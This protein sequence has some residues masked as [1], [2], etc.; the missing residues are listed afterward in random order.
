MNFEFLIAESPLAMFFNWI[1]H[2]EKKDTKE[3][4]KGVKFRHP[5]KSGS[6][7]IF[8]TRRTEMGFEH[9]IY[10]VFH[11]RILYT[12]CVSHVIGEASSL[13]CLVEK[14]AELRSYTLALTKQYLE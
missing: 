6:M 2:E 9:L 4:K 10:S 12:L 14:F 13:D 11:Q 3:R 5:D 1:Y 7:K 8:S